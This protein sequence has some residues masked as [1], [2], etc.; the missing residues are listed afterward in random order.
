MKRNTLFKT[1]L[2]CSIIVSAFLSSCDNKTQQFIE[3]KDVVCDSLLLFSNRQF[4]LVSDTIF[5]KC[6]VLLW[7]DSTRCSQCELERLDNYEVFSSHCEQ[8]IGKE[9]RMKVIISPSEQYGLGLLINDVQYLNHSFDVI[10]DYKNIFPSL[11]N[12]NDR[13]LMV[14]KDDHIVKFYRMENTESDAYKMR[15]CLDYLKQM[16]DEDQNN[17]HDKKH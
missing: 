6:S 1:L 4:T 7:I 14:L 16:Y 9:G 15:E 17:Y 10:I 2:F 8:I 3:G 12:C 11:F 5:N 13:L